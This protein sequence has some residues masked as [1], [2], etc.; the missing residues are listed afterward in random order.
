MSAYDIANN[1]GI[2]RSTVRNII[3]LFKRTGNTKP[4]KKTGRPT[5]ASDRDRRILRKIVK[6]DRRSTA[7]SIT[8]EWKH[9]IKKQV[10]RDTC[11]R[12]IKKNGLQIL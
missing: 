9:L 11:I 7:A 5:I 2:S 10:S 6:K 4:L 8:L 12:E 1:L 3:N